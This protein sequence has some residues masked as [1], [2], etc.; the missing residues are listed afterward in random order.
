M[1]SEEVWRINKA[2][3]SFQELRKEWKLFFNY[4]TA[5]GREQRKPQYLELW[6]ADTHIHLGAFQK[7]GLDL[8]DSSGSN[9]GKAKTLKRC[10]ANFFVIHTILSPLIPAL[11]DYRVFHFIVHFTFCQLHYD[12]FSWNCTRSQEQHLSSAWKQQL[13]RRCFFRWVSHGCR[14]FKPT[15]KKNLG[16]VVYVNERKIL[17]LSHA[18]L[19]H[20]ASPCWY[21]NITSVSQHP[22]LLSPQPLR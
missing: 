8:W 14:A 7:G 6:S 15:K 1:E 13:W 16:T 9:K 21:K 22:T 2:W 12:C 3:L 20:V 11:P 4:W 18:E 17:H 5:S 10:A 19:M